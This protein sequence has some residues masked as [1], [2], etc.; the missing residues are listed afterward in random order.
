VVPEETFAM[1]ISAPQYAVR[2]R[3]WADTCSDS[4][5]VGTR[6][7]ARVARRAGS[8]ISRDL[9]QERFNTIDVLLVTKTYPHFWHSK[10]SVR[11]AN[12]M[13]QSCHYPCERGRGCRGSPKLE[14]WLWIGSESVGQIPCLRGPVEVW[15]R[16]DEKRKQ[17]LL[18]CPPDVVPPLWI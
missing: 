13:Q 12:N 17:K 7:N 9:N 3:K 2:P 8:L 11:E 10:S 15:H 14:E 18:W 5:L 4:S 1:T 6:I 16:E